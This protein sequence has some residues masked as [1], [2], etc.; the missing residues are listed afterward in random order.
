MAQRWSWGSQ[1][2]VK[3]HWE[4]KKKFPLKKRSAVLPL[5]HWNI[6]NIN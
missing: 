6:K 5:R 1:K 2:E 3:K 4:E